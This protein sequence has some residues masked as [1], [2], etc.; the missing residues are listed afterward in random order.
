MENV[1]CTRKEEVIMKKYFYLMVLTL[2][3]FM[4]WVSDSYSATYAITQLT[5]NDYYDGEPRI[6]DNGHI[7]WSAKI[8]NDENSSEIFLYDGSTTIQLTDNDYWDGAPQ[9]N[10]NGQ[11][12]WMAILNSTD[13]NS[14]EIF[15]YDGSTTIQL[16]DN[17]Y[18][19][20]YPQ[21]NNNGQVVWSG[22]GKI[23]L[24]DGS[25]VKQLDYGYNP[26]INDNGQ[27]VWDQGSGFMLFYG[28]IFLYDGTTIKQLTDND[29]ADWAPQINDNGEVIWVRN[30][31]MF[32]EIYLYDGSTIKQFT[33]N[34]FYDEAPQ[35]NDNGQVVWHRETGI[36]NN[37]ALYNGSITKGLS[38]FKDSNGYPQ[39]N[40]N[41]HVVWT[42]DLSIGGNF[43]ESEI[44]FY[45]GSTTTKI[46]HNIGI[47]A[48]LHFPH[49]NDDD[50]IVFQGG[51]GELSE[52]YYVVISDTGNDS[53]DDGGGGGGGGCFIA[54]AAYGSSIEPHVKILREFR[55]RFMLNNF[56]GRSFVRV[57]YRYSPP[58]A[59]FIAKH[60]SL[61][62]MT[63]MGLLPIIGVSWIALR[64][65][66]V[67]SLALMFL[68]GSVLIGFIDIRRRLRKGS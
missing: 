18:S 58:V 1:S 68:L 13:T 12:A 59:H 9:I 11:V 23:F 35:I 45:N 8:N 46:D 29:D 51:V 40:N 66:P 54:T 5:D 60:P 41:G 27:V 19:D 6:N 33:D 43:Q 49:N 44:Y 64:V 55:D 57:Y 36:R 3:F 10:N 4:F 38:D 25:T 48:G 30:Y 2:V 52:I 34:D 31:G 67:Y 22:G 39:I 63:R 65:N 50:Y 21:I 62:F 28:E 14:I 56:I 20:S 61:R 53:G 16:T 7:V 42:R 15:L 37:I 26:Q 24:Y 17:D 32:S 47:I